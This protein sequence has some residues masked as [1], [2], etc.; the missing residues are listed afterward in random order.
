MHYYAELDGS[1]RCQAVTETSGTLSG[2]QFVPLTFLDLSRLGKTW[3][4]TT[5]DD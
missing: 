3:N 4:G 5:W 2:P 1:N